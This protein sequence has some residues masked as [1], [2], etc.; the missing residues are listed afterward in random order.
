MAARTITA[1]S[2]VIA[3][4]DVVFDD[5][6]TGASGGQNHPTIAHRVPCRAVPQVDGAVSSFLQSCDATD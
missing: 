5:G 1:T 4:P 6:D 2:R 3:W